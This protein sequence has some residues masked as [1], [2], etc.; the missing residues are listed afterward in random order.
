MKLDDLIESLNEM[1]GY[2]FHSS[3]LLL[4]YG[5]IS[6]GKSLEKS[7]ILLKLVDFANVQ[8]SEDK[9]SQCDEDLV[10]ALKN[11]KSYLKELYEIDSFDI[12]LN[13]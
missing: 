4:I 7:E 10:R 2:V 11:I 3:S 9:I 6:E 8:I 1:K 13:F 5:D 12:D